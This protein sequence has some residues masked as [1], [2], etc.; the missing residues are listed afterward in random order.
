MC[1][2]DTAEYWFYSKMPRTFNM[3]KHGKGIECGHN[4]NVMD[5]EYTEDVECYA[6][7]KLIQE[8]LTTGM[9]EGKAP[10]MYYMSNSEKKKYKKQKAFNE[11][12]GK[13]PCGCIWTIR[14]NSINKKE[15]LGCINYPKC[16]NT[17][18]L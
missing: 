17:K 12:Y 14:K 16:K 5:T 3:F 13:C 15:F 8:G 2:S 7:K 18:N 1:L 6:C 9:L 4:H 10:E 11:K